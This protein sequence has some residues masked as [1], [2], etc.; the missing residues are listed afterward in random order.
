MR[1]V[2]LAIHHLRRTWSFP[3]PNGSPTQILKRSSWAPSPSCNVAR[4]HGRLNLDRQAIAAQEFH[5]TRSFSQPARMQCEAVCKS[6]LRHS[7]VEE[8]MNSSHSCGCIMVAGL[9][10]ALYQQ[11]L[12]RPLRQ[13]A[14][15]RSQSV[16]LRTAVPSV[17]HFDSQLN[18]D[19]ATPITTDSTATICWQTTE[20]VTRGQ[21]PLSGRTLRLQTQGHHPHASGAD[22]PLSLQRNASQ[23]KGDDKKRVLTH[24]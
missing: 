8:M 10:V 21:H 5:T 24:T 20:L 6:Q 3:P 7:N 11:H 22:A 9:P 4:G 18:F 15:H 16:A 1:R 12:L 14:H 2:A 23:N 19:S 13:S 17:A